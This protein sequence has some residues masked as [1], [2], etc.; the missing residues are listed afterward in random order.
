MGREDA[1]EADEMQPW[2]GDKRGQALHE[3]Q[4]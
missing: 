2:M 4:G 3:L 1:M